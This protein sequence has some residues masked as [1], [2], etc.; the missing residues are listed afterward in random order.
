MVDHVKTFTCPNCHRDVEVPRDEP[1]L[2]HENSRHAP[3]L[4]A[5]VCP[6]GEHEIRLDD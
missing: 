1:W 6:H 5:F 2:V 3:T 4:V